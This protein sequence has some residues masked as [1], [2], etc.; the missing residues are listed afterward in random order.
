VQY[1]NKVV[2]RK[3]D[4]FFLVLISVLFIV[5]VWISVAIS[6]PCNTAATGFSYPVIDDNTTDKSTW[7]V[8]FNYFGHYLASYYGYHPGEDWNLVGGNSTDD[9][10]RPVRAVATG[11]VV[12]V[13]TLNGLGY[14]VAIKHIGNF[15]IPGKSSTQNE[16]SYTYPTENV[17]S[18]Y[19]VYIHLQNVAV[20]VNSCVAKGDILG[21]I[22]DPG[23]GPHLHF[24]IRH[25]NSQPSGDWSLNQST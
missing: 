9:L 20:S 5:L 7:G 12:K 8:P 4:S 2:Y 19:S 14:L 13:S 18:I 1:E 25:P 21:Y 15:V 3:R 23:A 11:T 16:Q 10:N 24:E 22:M 6:Q 17:T